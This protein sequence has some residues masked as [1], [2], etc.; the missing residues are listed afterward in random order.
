MLAAGLRHSIYVNQF[1]GINVWGD[2]TF[3]QLGKPYQDVHA[4]TT[5]YNPLGLRRAR[6]LGSGW[7]HILVATRPTK[8]RNPTLWSWGLGDVGQ[9]GIGPIVPLGG[10][11]FYQVR[12]PFAVLGD[13]KSKNFVMLKG[14]TAHSLALTSNGEVLSWGWNQVGQLGLGDLT[15]R[16][17]A[18]RIQS[19]P[20]SIVSIAAGGDFSL[21]LAK[22]GMVWAWGNN[23]RD[24]LGSGD[25]TGVPMTTPIRID[26]AL[27]LNLKAIAA[28]TA[29][30][31]A[32]DAKGVVYSWGDNSHGQ[33]GRGDDPSLSVPDIVYGLPPITAIAAGGEYAL[34]L[35]KNGVLWAWGLNDRG[36]LGDGTTLTRTTPQP[37]P[38]LD[39]IQIMAA[40]VE[41]ALALKEGGVLMAWGDDRAYQLGVQLAEER[42]LKPLIVDLNKQSKKVR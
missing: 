16:W 32:L 7:N 31:L 15:N 9:L 28:G 39:K 2:N 24:Q 26:Q 34:A 38:G 12:Q 8:T 19:L 25:R 13:I 6:V 11:A 5:P 4:S 20:Q 22:D 27:G 30:A 37:V 14:G 3:G 36:Q 33:L 35:D 41:H 23:A 29:F 40:G 21:A 18:M 42:S 10:M 17:T 1:G